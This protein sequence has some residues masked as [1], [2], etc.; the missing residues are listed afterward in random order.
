MCLT[1]VAFWWRG[2]ARRLL[3]RP[4]RLIAVSGLLL[5]AVFAL[6]LCSSPPAASPPAGDVQA[7]V[8]IKELM[9]NVV[10]PIADRV[11]DAVAVDVTEKGVVEHR[12]TTDEDW[13]SVRQGAVTLAESSNLLKMPRAVAPAGEPARQNDP[14]GPELAPA[15]IQ[16]HIDAD[17]ALWN[18]HADDLRS[19]GLK[20]LEIVEARDTDKLFQAGSELDA[21][22]ENCHLEYWYPGDRAAV[23]EDRNKKVYF[24][25]KK[26]KPEP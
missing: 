11:F 24:E 3:A 18:R 4:A 7:V 1:G 5:V 25:T 14:N 13:A 23:L 9:E 17:R 15:E 22:C 6:Q 20:I 8:S 16:K 12:P 26:P 19:E 2:V 21:V 10:D